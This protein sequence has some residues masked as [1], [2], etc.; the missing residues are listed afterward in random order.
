MKTFARDM[1]QGRRRRDHLDPQARGPRRLRQGH[2]REVRAQGLSDPRA[3]GRHH[4]RAPEH[5]RRAR[6]GEGRAGHARADRLPGQAGRRAARWTRRRRPLPALP[7]HRRGPADRPHARV[8]DRH[9]GDE[10]ALRDDGHRDPARAPGG[11]RAGSA[12]TSAPTSTTSSTTSSRRSTSAS[13]RWPPSSGIPDFISRVA[14]ASE[15]SGA[16]AAHTGLGADIA[17]LQGEASRLLRELVE[18]KGAEYVAGM[19]H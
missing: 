12:S 17:A 7:H 14:Q 2:P 13:R 11:G 8:A 19:F 3:D 10:H 5:H 4:P 1:L 15:R 9:E 18:R 6:G 16:G